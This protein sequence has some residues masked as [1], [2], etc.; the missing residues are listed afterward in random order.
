[1]KVL[2][3]GLMKFGDREAVVLELCDGR[4][5][6]LIVSLSSEKPYFEFLSGDDYLEW[7]RCL[8]KSNMS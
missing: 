6:V 8:Q 5:L 7:V 1:V 2:A 3:E 4:Q